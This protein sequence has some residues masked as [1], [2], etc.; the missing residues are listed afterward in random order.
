MNGGNKKMVKEG[1]GGARSKKW[2]YEWMLN[3]MKQ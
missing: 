1:Y 2:R 3:L